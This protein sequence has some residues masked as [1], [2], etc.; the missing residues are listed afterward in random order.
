M[1]NYFTS[2]CLLTRLGVDNIRATGV[3][4]K[5]SLR[6]CITIG[7]KQLQKKERGH[8][9]QSTSRKKAV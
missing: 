1:D 4:N 8:F 9:K 2:F 3:L 6:K 5:N 7:E